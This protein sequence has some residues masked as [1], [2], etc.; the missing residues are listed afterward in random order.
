MTSES[1]FCNDSGLSETLA[2][3]RS[4][5]RIL[6]AMG[7]VRIVVVD[8]RAECTQSF[9]HPGLSRTSAMFGL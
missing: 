1:Y 5:W 3:L 8:I 4:R 6:R 2:S 9:D 7:H